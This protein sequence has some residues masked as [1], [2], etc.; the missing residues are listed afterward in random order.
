MQKDYTRWH[1]VKSKI[2]DLESNTFFQEREIWW[3]S[4]GANVGYEQD[5]RGELFARPVVILTKFNLDTCLMVPLTAKPKSGKYYFK[6]GT[7]EGREA[8]A[9]LSQIRHLDRKRLH[10]KMATVDQQLFAELRAAV[11]AACFPTLK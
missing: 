1:P 11:I 8:T 3:C 7:L 4:L 10:S 9:N 6:I 2:N 5:G